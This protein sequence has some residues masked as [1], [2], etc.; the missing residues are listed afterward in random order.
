MPVFCI[1]KRHS[2]LTGKALNKSEFHSHRS[3][4]AQATPLVAENILPAVRILVSIKPL[5]APWASRGKSLADSQIN[6]S[7]SPS[8][9]VYGTCSSWEPDG[10]SEL[11]PHRQSFSLNS[12]QELVIRR[13]NMQAPGAGRRSSVQVS[14]RRHGT[15]PRAARDQAAGG[16]LRTAATSSGSR[17]R[18]PGRGHGVRV[19]A[20]PSVG[21]APAREKETRPSGPR[22]PRSGAC[23]SNRTPRGL[24]AEGG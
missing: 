13:I 10:D 21:C 19:S 15:R 18:G 20:A 12:T 2:P 9:Y 6:L 16:T 17:A 8:V 4:L 7:P 22:A 11:R 3:P 1:E 23:I 24:G 5:S 14:S